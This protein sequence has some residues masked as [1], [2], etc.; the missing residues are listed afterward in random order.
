MFAD[1][2]GTG[3]GYFACG[4]KLVPIKWSR[5]NATAPFVYSLEDGT[6]L[7]LGIGKSYVAVLPTGSP[8][9]YQ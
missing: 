4:G 3:N 1:L 8:V 6:P 7:T 2:E 9:E 5:E